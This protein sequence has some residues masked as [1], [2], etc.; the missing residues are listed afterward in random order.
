M[1]KLIEYLVFNKG[2]NNA[3]TN[4]WKGNESVCNFF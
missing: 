2:D 3:V 1:I 4:K